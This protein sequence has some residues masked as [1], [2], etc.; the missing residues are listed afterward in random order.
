MP[1]SAK[2]LTQHAFKQVCI[3]HKRAGAILLAALQVDVY[4]ANLSF[5]FGLAGFFLALGLQG[6]FG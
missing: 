2:I 3:P 5:F 6:L 1:D 4:R